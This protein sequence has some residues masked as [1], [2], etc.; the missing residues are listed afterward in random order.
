[1]NIA[2]WLFVLILVYTFISGIIIGKQ[3]QAGR[4]NPAMVLVWP[5]WMTAKSVTW[6][7]SLFEVG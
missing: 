3:A 7:V 5:L 2:I 6:F 1:M 4:G